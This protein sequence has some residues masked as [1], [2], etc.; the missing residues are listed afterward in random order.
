MSCNYAEKYNAY[1]DRTVENIITEVSDNPNIMSNIMRSY[2]RNEIK[3]FMNS[4]EILFSQMRIDTINNT[5]NNYTNN[6]FNN[7]FNSNFTDNYSDNIVITKRNYNKVIS[8]P[9]NEVFD[10]ILIDSDNDV[11]NDVDNDMI[12]NNMIYSDNE[13]D[14]ENGIINNN[15]KFGEVEFDNEIEVD[16]NISISSLTEFEFLSEPKKNKNR[17]EVDT[18]FDN[19]YDNEIENEYVDNEIEFDDEHENKQQKQNIKNISLDSSLLLQHEDLT[20]TIKIHKQRT[21]IPEKID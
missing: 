1:L 7:N 3:T 5:F 17:I 4:I 19:E 2:I 12:E 14:I 10:N 18:E 20:P 6:T 15:L 21:K 11:D 8:I 13:N 9:S 16:D